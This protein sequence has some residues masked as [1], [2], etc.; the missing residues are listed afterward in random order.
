MKIVQ[1]IPDLALAGAERMMESLTLQLK[2]EGFDVEVV[3]LYDYH[4][5]ITDNLEKN[6]IKIHYLKKKKGMDLSM[7]S[8][9][10]KLFK[11][12]KPDVVHTHRHVSQYTM[13]A[14][15]LAGV[16]VRVHTVHNMAD[17]ESS[18][19]KLQNIFIHHFRMIPVAISDIVQESICKL[20]N[21]EKNMVPIV[22]N[23]MKL[24]KYR[25]KESYEIKNGIFRIMHIGRF[26]RQK[27]HRGLIEG[28]ACFHENYPETK[29]F[30][31]GDGELKGDIQALI[32]KLHLENSV[33]L[34]GIVDNINEIMCSYDMFIL[35]SDYEGMPITLIEAM[36]SGMPIAASAVGGV[37]DMIENEIN[38][39]LTG[40]DT[41]SIANAMKR[42]YE[43]KEL[44]K[45]L[46]SNAVESAKKYS[47][48][49]MTKGYLEIYKG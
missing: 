19:K 32:K 27:N 20:Y 17:K 1:I 23:G 30:L 2:E 7:I 44:R 8:K 38:G 21:L 33:E 42:M 6:S 15:I 5:D 31:Y 48:E 18:A 46:G 24:E 49:N 35:P 29:L 43:S 13:P 16:P 12:L 3:S 9:L 28:F 47:V 22:Y 11:Q 25:R 34:C 45:K 26:S 10:I 36:A 14:C 4:S 40:P 39:I 37:P 41:D